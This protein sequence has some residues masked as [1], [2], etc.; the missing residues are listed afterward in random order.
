MMGY[1]MTVSEVVKALNANKYILARCY[2]QG[3]F[4][5]NC[6]IMKTKHTK[7]ARKQRHGGQKTTIVGFIPCSFHEYLSHKKGFVIG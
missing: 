1:R 7:R 3:L 6:A 5:V 2:Y 4:G